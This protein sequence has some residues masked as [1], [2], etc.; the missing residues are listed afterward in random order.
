M[1]R[2]G[3]ILSLVALIIV[4]STS[5]CFA[6]TLTLN[7]SYPKDGSKGA[8]IE[9]LGI[10]LYFDTELTAEAVEAANEGAF[11]LYGPEG[12]KLP[13]R[14]LYPE[15]EEGVVLVLLDVTYDGDGDGKADYTNAVSN[16]EY[17]L[18]ISGSLVD[19]AGNTLGQDKTI[20]FTTLNQQASM[21][22]NMV[23]MFG[24]MFGMMFLTAREAKKTA[25][26]AAK[27]GGN[28]E[29]AFNPY[30]EAKRTGKSVQE[31]IAQHEKEMAKKAA[32][33]ARKHNDEDDYEWIDIN[34]Y[35]VAKRRPI[36]EGGSSYITGR[37]AIAEAKKAEEAARKAAKAEAKRN[38]KKGKGK[39]KK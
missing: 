31:V 21:M 19:D 3:K 34:T 17:K 26:E 16:S 33:D 7:D 35:R 38:V 5:L 30:K 11:Q 25:E 36:S 9:N 2:A 14:V 24:M 27:K 22:I 4:L 18:Q 13:T 8:A 23:M 37:K 32:R 20:T 28:R 10:K 39:K 6:G 29:E 12:E 1:K 15:A